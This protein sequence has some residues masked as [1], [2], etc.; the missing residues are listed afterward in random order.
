MKRL[1]CIQAEQK[2]CKALQWVSKENV[3]RE[4]RPSLNNEKP[5]N[6]LGPFIWLARVNINPSFL[7]GGFQS[8]HL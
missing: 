6:F 5:S 2:V 1:V 8:K 7:L 3:S 4:Y